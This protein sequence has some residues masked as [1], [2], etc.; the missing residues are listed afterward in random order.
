MTEG[1]SHHGAA[2]I[3]TEHAL[4]ALADAAPSNSAANASA[5]ASA[6]STMTEGDSHHGAAI[7]VSLVNGWF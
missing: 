7:R 6:D 1:D 5:I 3:V 4:T 2:I